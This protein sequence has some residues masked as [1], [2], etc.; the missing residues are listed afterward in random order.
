ML[1]W[2]GMLLTK[3]NRWKGEREGGSLRGVQYTANRGQEWTEDRTTSQRRDFQVSRGE[4]SKG[5]GW[6][7]QAKTGLSERG[8]EHAPLCIYC[9]NK[10]LCLVYI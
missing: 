8:C 5:D 2:E 9:D 10:R 4:S 1:S 7:F 3:G 6:D